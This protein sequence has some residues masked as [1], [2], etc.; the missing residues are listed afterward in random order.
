MWGTRNYR[1]D[2]NQ[3]QAWTFL[4]GIPTSITQYARPL[5][6]TEHLNAA[7]GVYAQDRWTMGRLTLNVGLRFDYHNAQVPVQ[8]LAAIPF[9]PARHYDAIDDVPNWKDLSPR[10]G[11]TFDLFGNGKSIVRAAYNRYVASESTNMATLNNRVNTSIN[12][13]TRNWTDTN[14]NFTPDCDLSNPGAQTVPG[15]DACGQLNAPLGNLNVAAAYDSAITSGFGVRPNDQEVSAGFQQELLPR[16]ALD[17][18][19]TR[20]SFGNFIASANTTRPPSAY[21]SYCVTAPPDSRLPNGGGNQICGFMDLN[22]SFFATVPFFQVQK[23]S[24]FGDVTDVYTGYDLNANARLA[25]G[26]VVSGGFSLGH[27]VTDICAV[28]GQ[29]TVTYAGVAGVLAS[30]AGTI[31]NFATTA[32]VQAPSTLYCRVEPP[33]QA[34]VKGFVSYPLPWFGLNASATLQNRPGPQITATYTITAAQAQN[35]DRALGTSTAATQLIAP[36]TM[37][38]DRVTQVDARVGKSF[39]MQRYRLQASMDVFNLLNSSAILSQNN[40]F[41]TSWLSP[42]QILQGRLIKFGMQLEF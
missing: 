39:R 15:G 32:S 26:G 2:T 27:E 41:G 38:G 22:P 33:F 37:Y 12:S 6:D 19:F 3:S 17:F 5:I 30:S 13:A 24:T 8:D 7:L 40:T 1:Y 10:A 18:Q 28:A 29:A 25:R 11:G 21:Q 14:G 4:R 23:A 35:L 34:D 9:V 20:H 16:V 42:T 31:Q 36:G